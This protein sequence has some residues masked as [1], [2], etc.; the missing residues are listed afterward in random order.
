MPASARDILRNPLKEKLARG[1]TASSITVRLVRSVEIARLA[2]TAGFDSLYVDMEHNS[3]SLDATGQ[4]CIAALDAG[5]APLVRVPAGRPD[6]I[7]RVLDGGALGIIAPHV[8][9]AEE[10]REVVRCALLPPLGERSHGGPMPHLGYRSLPQAEADEA[11]NAATMVVLM[12]ETRSALDHVEAIAAVP[13]VDML[14]IGTNDLCSELGITGQYDHALVREAYARSIAACR[15]HGKHVG[16]GGLASRAD[17][18]AEFVR[19]GARYV[20][21]GSDLGFLL[22]AAT[23]RAR[24]VQDIGAQAERPPESAPEH[25]TRHAQ[26]PPDHRVG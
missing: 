4:I 16:V 17:L 19:L 5:I 13:G 7:A 11:L 25:P 2:K 15:R 24:A 18:V 14:L 10:A 9:T 21:T 3:F 1:E 8:H 22:E 6:C 12:M 23:A 20:S 26:E